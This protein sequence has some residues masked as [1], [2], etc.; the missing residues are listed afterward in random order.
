VAQY[1]PLASS[2]TWIFNLKGTKTTTEEGRKAGGLKHPPLLG[3]YY[4]AVVGLVHGD[5]VVGAIFFLGVDA[6]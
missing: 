3:F 4:A 6:G 2:S 1:N 5:Y